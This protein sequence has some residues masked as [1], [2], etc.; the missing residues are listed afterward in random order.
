MQYYMRSKVLKLW[1][2]WEDLFSAH[3]HFLNP[4]LIVTIQPCN[5]WCIILKIRRGSSTITPITLSKYLVPSSNFQDC[6]KG[7]PQNGIKR[8]DGL[9]VCF[10]CVGCIYLIFQAVR[11]NGLLWLLVLIWLLQSSRKSTTKISALNTKSE[12]KELVL[13]LNRKN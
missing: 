2:H 8:L 10:K 1:I 4:L 5:N 11:K 3:E 6:L 13:L 12:M 7:N 9:Q